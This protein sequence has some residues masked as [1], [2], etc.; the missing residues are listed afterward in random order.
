MTQK[1]ICICVCLCLLCGCSQLT[2]KLN[3]SQQ[4]MEHNSMGDSHLDEL[5]SSGEEA[6]ASERLASLLAA[7]EGQDVDA[8]LDMFSQ[9]A[10]E[11]AEDLHQK[12]EELFSMLDGEIVSQERLGGHIGSETNNGSISKKT[13]FSF[14]VSTE[15]EQFVVCISE[16]IADEDS[17]RVGIN[18][19]IAYDFAC[20][21]QVL[22][23]PEF[24][25]YVQRDG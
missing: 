18:Q 12:T 11:E 17:D 25:I 6:I 23:C 7:R 21:G 2:D 16:C 15:S 24:G 10:K 5:N 14:K 22:N 3:V 20:L 13:T 8:V 19:I 9:K 4:E 1:M